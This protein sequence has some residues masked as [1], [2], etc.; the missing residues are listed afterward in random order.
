LQVIPVI[1]V[2]HGVVV[3]A[4]AGD[5]ASYQPIA[6][7]LFEGCA[8]YS[9]FAGLMALHPF[10]VIYCADLDAIEGR[11]V[12]VSLLSTLADSHPGVGLWGDAGARSLHD[13]AHQLSR[14]N[15]SAV[16]GSEIGV[17]AAELRELVSNFG[18]RIILS[19]DYRAIGF[20]GDPALLADQSC[21]PTRVIAM[22][23]AN[24][25]MGQGPDIATIAA[26]KQRHGSGLIYAAGGIRN[27][28][29]L[30]A[31]HQAGAHGALISSALHAQ[32]ITADD[33]G[34]V[35]DR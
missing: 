7:P 20:V 15:I 29:D 2:R 22:T 10:P 17:T 30:T 4:V 27:A 23:L 1:D 28:A 32:T 19:L 12:N 3:R 6:S 18:D 5:R 14:P 11:G 25:G 21:W 26:L 8:P 33:L 31:A 13:V 35:T 34:K 9:A 24:V 16:I